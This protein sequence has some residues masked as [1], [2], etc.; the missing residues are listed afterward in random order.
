MFMLPHCSQRR[1]PVNFGDPFVEIIIVY[2]AE[3]TRAKNLEYLAKADG[4]KKTDH[5]T[6]IHCNKIP[7]FEFACIDR[8]IQRIS[9]INCI[10]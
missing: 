7:S 5:F 2:R 1:L 10:A 8:L 9:N 6:R 4:L 3:K